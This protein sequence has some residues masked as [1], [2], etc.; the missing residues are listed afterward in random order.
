MSDIQP[1]QYL[2][3]SLHVGTQDLGPWWM[4][5][6]QRTGIVV[7]E[8]SEDAAVERLKKALD[9]VLDSFGNTEADLRALE[10]YLNRRGVQYESEPVQKLRGFDIIRDRE[11]IF[12]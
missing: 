4:A 12:A 10:D 11:A 2:N 9:L 5:F 3:L 1:G 7:F 6:E 8:D